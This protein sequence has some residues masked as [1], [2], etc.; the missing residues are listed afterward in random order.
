LDVTYDVNICRNDRK[1]NNSFTYIS[2]L[3]IDTNIKNTIQL[4]SFL[5]G[6]DLEKVIFR[7]F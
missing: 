1:I 4:S 5:S 7:Y 3:N 2:I 6:Y